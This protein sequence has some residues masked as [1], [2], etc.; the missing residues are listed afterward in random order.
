MTQEASC[1]CNLCLMGEFT[2]HVTPFP[3]PC[4]EELRILVLA[5]VRSPS[6]KPTFIS[7]VLEW[8]RLRNTDLPSL[9]WPPDGRGWEGPRSTKETP[10]FTG[11]SLVLGPQSKKEA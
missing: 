6:L 7:R 10:F 2:V 9:D 1:R 3:S 4:V 11:A 5:S 8:P